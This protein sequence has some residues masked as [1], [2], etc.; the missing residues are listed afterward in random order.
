MEEQAAAGGAAGT[1]HLG[2]TVY[3]WQWREQNDFLVRCLAPVWE[4]LDEAGLLERVWFDRYDARGPHLFCVLTPVEGADPDRLARV[5]EPRLQAYLEENPASAELSREELEK[6]HAE[7]RGRS[8]SEVDRR[9]GFGEPGTFELC[10][11]PD[12]GYPFPIERLIP[13][14]RREGLWRLVDGL[15]RWTVERI[16]AREGRTP[17]GAGLWLIASV[18]RQLRDLHGDSAPYWRHHAGSLLSRLET[19]LQ[20]EPRQARE[21]IE[22]LVKDETRTVLDG[23]WQRVER[24]ETLWPR[25][26]QL[27]ETITCGGEDPASR[28][29]WRALREVDHFTLK[30]LG[31]VVRMHIPPV[32]YALLRALDDE[33]AAAAAGGTA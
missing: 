11:H 6:R 28:R 18:D 12:D 19:A 1:Q 2:V 3:L 9:E 27:V 4:T 5:V 23:L 20:E 17:V 13:A 30:Q 25:H 14:P 33:G 22:G 26:R 32:L 21:E 16:A 10:R 8:Q 15:S 29:R 31:L 7:C 24:G